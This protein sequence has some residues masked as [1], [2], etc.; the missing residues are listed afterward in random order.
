MTENP[1]RL[2]RDVRG[3]GFKTADAITMRFG[4]EKTAMIRACRAFPRPDALVAASLP[5]V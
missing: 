4:V 1:Y 2:T 3:I 5:A